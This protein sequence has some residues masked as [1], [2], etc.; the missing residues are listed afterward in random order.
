MSNMTSQEFE[1]VHRLH[2]QHADQ[3]L[4]EATRLLLQLVTNVGEDIA[5]E[6]MSRHLKDAL[7]SA[8]EFLGIDEIDPEYTFKVIAEE[9]QI[10]GSEVTKTGP[11]TLYCYMPKS[12]ALLYWEN[13]T[14]WLEPEVGHNFADILEGPYVKLA[15]YVNDCIWENQDIKVIA[16]SHISIEPENDNE[17]KENNNG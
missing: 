17:E 11:M 7:D 15:Q 4:E 13:Q 6:E 10:D 8:K 12:D 5:I 16:Y 14:V 2:G 1:R 3:T 9:W